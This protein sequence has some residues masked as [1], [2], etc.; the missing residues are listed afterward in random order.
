MPEVYTY[1]AESA[2]RMDIGERWELKGRVKRTLW[3]EYYSR[4]GSMFIP[5]CNNLRWIEYRKQ[6]GTEINK[7]EC[8]VL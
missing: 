6:H 1:S 4:L 5:K 2:G 8:Q 7:G 3:L